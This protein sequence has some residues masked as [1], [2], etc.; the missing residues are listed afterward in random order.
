M[1]ISETFLHITRSSV[2]ES[3]LYNVSG[4]E[5]KRPNER[6]VNNRRDVLSDNFKVNSLSRKYP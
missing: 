6:N 5:K 1:M 3:M 4:D 2:F